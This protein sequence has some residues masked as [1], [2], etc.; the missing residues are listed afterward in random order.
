MYLDSCQSWCYIYD[1]SIMDNSGKLRIRRSNL[2]NLDGETVAANMKKRYAF[3]ETDLDI[4][5]ALPCSIL[6]SRP[7]CPA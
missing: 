4:S 6:D 1:E 7:V 5:P 2:K 3:T